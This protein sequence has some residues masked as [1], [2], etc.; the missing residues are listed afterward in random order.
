MRM[1]RPDLNTQCGTAQTEEDESR[2][3]IQESSCHND[4]VSRRTD[5]DR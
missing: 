2:E 1:N 4:T 3:R 5:P